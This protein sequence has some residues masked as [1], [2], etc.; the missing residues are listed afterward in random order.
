MS[1]AWK[2]SSALVI[3]S[4]WRRRGAGSEAGG[5]EGGSGGGIEGGSEGGTVARSEEV[6]LVEEERGSNEGREAMWLSDKV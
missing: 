3:I 6:S 2:A 1:R 4:V 5:S